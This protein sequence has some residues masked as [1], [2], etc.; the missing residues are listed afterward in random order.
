MNKN[1]IILYETSDHSVKLNVSTDG[2]TVWL[3]R[4]QLAEL[5]GRDIKTIGKHVN[6]VL[7]EELSDDNSVV[8]NFATTAAD[9][10]TYQVE[11]YNLDVII[12]VGY[13]V[14]SKRGVEFRRWANSVLKDYIIKGYAVNNKRID[15]IG[16]VIRIMKRAE[17][18]LDAKQ[19][20]SV[21]ERFNTALDL[22]DAYDH[23]TMRKPSGSK[24]VYVLNYD[25]CRR[26]ID[27]MKFASG[28]SLF[29]N[30][31]DDSF[32]GSISN[33]YQ[34]F[35][36]VEL[37]PTLEEK[38]AN[39][40]YFVTKNHSFSDGNKRIAAT[41]FLYFLDKNGALFLDDKKTEKAIADQT[42]AALT[43]MIAESQPSEKE[44][45]INVIMNCMLR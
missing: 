37:Y 1:E 16:E 36:G 43:I 25:E 10:K 45:M 30:E 19:V 18:Q 21:I 24:A 8:A 33:I 44:M 4:A 2:K 32:K 42:L 7:K 29:G 6:N 23:Q 11:Y 12:S 5:F 40:L 9:G 31:K 14:K 20:L 28:S 3:N 38:A 26:V 22:L 15:Q 39:L 17:N 34:E 13:R 35:D 27:E 41:M